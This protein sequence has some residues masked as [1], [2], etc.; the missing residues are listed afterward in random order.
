MCYLT[1]TI[2]NLFTNK[3]N[4][5]NTDG[6]GHAVRDEAGLGRVPGRSAHLPREEWTAMGLP[7]LLAPDRAYP[8][9]GT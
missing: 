9:P 6:D 8:G 2:R 3:N 1:A 4:P 5:G 7:Q